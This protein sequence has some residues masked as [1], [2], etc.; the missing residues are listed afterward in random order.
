MQETLFPLLGGIGLFLL[1]MKLLTDGLVA[2]AG[3]NLRRALVH[4]TGTPYRAFLSGAL[5][6]VL[7]QSSTAT[8][9]ALIGFVSAG[10]ISFAQAIG[11]VIGA[12]LG[13]TATG[14]IV[15]GLGLKINLGFYTLPLI[16]IGALLKLLWRGRWAELGLVLAGFGMLFLGLNT[17]QEGM[18]GVA[19]AFNLADLPAGGYGARM[20]IMIIGLALTAVLQSSTAAIAM[21]LTA[22]HTNTI[23]FDQAAAM[24]I[25]A[26]IGTTLTGALVTI[27]GTVYAKRTALAHILFNLCTG[28]L[29]IALL[30]AFTFAVRL[31]EKHLGVAPGAISIAIFHTL[32]I[33]TGVAIFLP[34]TPFFTNVLLRMLPDRQHDPAAHLDASLL[35]IPTVALDAAQRTLEH[36]AARLLTI[37]DQLL[38]A[39]PRDALQQDLAAMQRTL[40]H[41]FEFISR[42]PLQTSERMLTE[43]R[44]AQLHAADHL[45]RLRARLDEVAQAETD[46]TASAYQWALQQNREL[47][48]LAQQALSDGGWEQRLGNIE[49]AATSLENLAHQNR[50]ALLQGTGPG[51]D[52]SQALQTTETFRWL[53]RTSKHI[54]RICHYLAQSRMASD[55]TD[56]NARKSAVMATDAG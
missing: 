52:T 18:H 41:T 27:G 51:S 31:F 28:L 39:A 43:T 47:L 29:A 24:V 13:N 36:A 55:H 7:V 16:G 11:V 45:L 48:S 44:V 37:Y 33:G 42:I 6:T 46:F 8:T 26:S 22:L 23:N 38:A 15:A 25:G 34:L 32:F 49:Q 20:V 40:N 4:F 50:H 1:G 12:S 10:L 3:E 56:A 17:L 53:D 30:P 2:F 35:S 19:N 21:T 9:V 14:W 54:W 5:V